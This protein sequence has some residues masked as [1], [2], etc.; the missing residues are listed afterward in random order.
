M[1]VPLVWTNIKHKIDAIKLLSLCACRPLAAATSMR[2]SR[3]SDYIS[4]FASVIFFIAKLLRFNRLIAPFDANLFCWHW[5]VRTAHLQCVCLSLSLIVALLII[6]LICERIISFISLSFW[7]LLSFYFSVS[8]SLPKPKQTH[9][10]MHRRRRVEPNRNI[11]TD[12][13]YE[14]FKRL[15][16]CLC[17]CCCSLW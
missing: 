12:Y 16:I 1:E 11:V 5:R 2:T 10:L 7:F 15:C 14:E 13:N 17:R 6:H 4:F 8:F 3:C 9:T